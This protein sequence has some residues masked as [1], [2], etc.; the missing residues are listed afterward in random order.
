VDQNLPPSA[1]A[2]KI[3]ITA[4]EVEGGR[5]VIINGHQRLKLA[6]DLGQPVRVR[7]HKLD[8]SVVIETVGSKPQ[9]KPN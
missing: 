9:E 7:V 6:L 2:E 8:G 1:T 3:M 5:L 4:R